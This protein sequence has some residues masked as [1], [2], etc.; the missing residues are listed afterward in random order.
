MAIFFA[1]VI[2]LTYICFMNIR[3][4]SSKAKNEKK[5]FS[6]LQKY[7][8]STEPVDK[9]EPCLDDITV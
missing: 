3:E 9:K 5:A 1:V 7:Q 4:R 8:P 2:P 6:D